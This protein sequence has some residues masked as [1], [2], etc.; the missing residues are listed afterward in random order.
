MELKVKIAGVQMEPT[1]LSKQKNIE[2]CLEL[3]RI[4]SR[5]GAK[6]IVFPECALTGYCYSSLAEALPFAESIPGPSTDVLIGVCQE[7]GVY[8]VVVLLEEDTDK[9]YNAAALLGPEG[10][11]GKYRK[12]HLPYLGVDRFV[13]HG[14][15]PPTVYETEIGRIGMGICFDGNFP[16]HSRV[17]ALKGADIIALPTNWPEGVEFIPELVIPT[18]ALEN[19]VFFAAVNRV[20]HE[21]GFRFFGRSRIAHPFGFVLADGKP[22]QEDILYA[23]IEPARAREKHLVLLPGEHE[24]SIFNDRRPEF[25]SQITDPLDDTSRIRK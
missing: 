11:V 20:G 24:V 25:Y 9:V 6:L 19:L 8:A 2:R 21:R 15:L 16:E 23:E 12:L 22:N 1:I 4:T 7:L 13:N 5:E 3:I 18:R 17:L 14:D 10:L